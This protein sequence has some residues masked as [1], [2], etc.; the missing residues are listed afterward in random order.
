MASFHHLAAANEDFPRYILANPHDHLTALPVELKSYVVQHL[1]IG[2]L[3]RLAQTSPF[4]KELITP[5]MYKRDNQE[6]YPRAIFWAASVDPAEVDDETIDT[7]LD[8]ALI[9]GGN[10]NK[11]YCSTGPQPFH[12]TPLH[13]AAA[14]GNLHVVK[15]LL[16]YGANPNAL[17]MG[18]LYNPILSLG[19]KEFDERMEKIGKEVAVS[20]RSSLWRPLFVP[21]VLKHEGIIQALLR[22][23][24]SPILATNNA[25]RTDSD[26]FN[27]LHI[28]ASQKDREYKDATG[29]SYFRRYASLINVPISRGDAP[30]SMAMRR[31]NLDLIKDI[32]TNGGNVEG[33]SDIG[34]TPLIQ[35][36][37]CFISGKTPEIRKEY[38]DLIRYLVEVCNASVGRHSD[39]RVFQTPLGC[40]A[41]G[42]TNDLQFVTWKNST[43]DIS[44]IINLLLDHGAD[45]NERP[46]HGYSLLNVL[47]W[48]ISQRKKKNKQSKNT[49]DN[50]AFL[51][52]FKELVIKRGADVNALLPSGSSM[53]AACIVK[54]GREPLPFFQTLLK[55]NA[56]LTDDEINPIFKMWV[57]NRSL[58]NTDPPFNM[59]VYSKG[60][61]Q[62][63]VD[64][65]YRACINGEENIFK[66]LQDHF[67]RSKIPQKIAAVALIQDDDLKRFSSAMRFENLKGSYIHTD[68][69][70][71]LHLIV[72]RLE[73]FPSYKPSQAIANARD[74]LL[75]GA[76]I[77]ARNENGE[78]ASDKLMN[79]RM[80]G[81][82][83]CD[84][85]R[86]FLQDVEQGNRLLREKYEAKTIS[87]DEYEK[88]CTELIKW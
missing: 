20:A 25:D 86:H 27:I 58:R 61:T 33:V 24:A 10:L 79:M 52:L 23:G 74:V 87:K 2:D 26:S 69:N 9:Y 18:F 42:F 70:N 68:G 85:L 16:N 4:F 46:E 59:L 5:I 62:E 36:I 72:K 39:T 75:L 57:T 13:L 41:R 6:K 60:I 19:H 8:L 73:T 63:S 3:G 66:M 51:E 34:T 44:S 71:F 29:L 48:V 32:I 15:K 38:M 80:Q 55:L 43:K 35:A 11:T 21:F 12:A 67:P 54:F 31:S 49:L 30:L 84:H 1:S 50:G 78:T 64:F 82:K 45:I 53:L 22:K 77:G 65:A 40:A 83:T 47:C 28:I 56:K 88:K 76:S 7:V 81:T 14:R 17:G 37:K